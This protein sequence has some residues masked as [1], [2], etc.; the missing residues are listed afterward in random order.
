MVGNVDVIYTPTDNVIAAGMATVAMVATD[1]G[2]AVICGEGGMV[3]AGGLATYGIDYY[4]LGYL[5]GQQAVEILT[6]GASPATTPIGYLSA[7]KCE[8]AVNEETAA[9]LGIDLSVV[10]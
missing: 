3:N 1:N 9:A 4:Q 10:K 5:A 2:L 6:N 8:L 7:D